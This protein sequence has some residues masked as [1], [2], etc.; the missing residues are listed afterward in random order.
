MHKPTLYIAE[1]L[2]WADAH[3]KRT[4]QW[5][6]S[7]S[8]SIPET[9]DTTWQGVSLALSVGCRGLRGGSSLAQLLAEHRGVRNIAALPPLEV[10][11]ILDWAD[12]FHGRTGQWPRSD[13]GP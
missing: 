2:E 8:G 6:K 5:P 12:A 9:I 4:G 11:R 7:K 3:H 13:S 10:E 1:I